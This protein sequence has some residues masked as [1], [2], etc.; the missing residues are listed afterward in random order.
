[1]AEEEIQE[2]NQYQTEQQYNIDFCVCL[3]IHFILFW[4]FDLSVMVL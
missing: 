3:S 2:Q 4:S 1:M